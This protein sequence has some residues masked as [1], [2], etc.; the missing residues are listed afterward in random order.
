M[1]FGFVSVI[2]NSFAALILVEGASFPLHGKEPKRAGGG[3]R[4]Q[5]IILDA[6]VN[7]NP[8]RPVMGGL[9][10]ID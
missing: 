9:E 4:I 6:T 10:S 7:C 2:L 5:A 3:Y 1:L 8:F